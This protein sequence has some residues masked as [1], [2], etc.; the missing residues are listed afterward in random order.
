VCAVAYSYQPQTRKANSPAAGSFGLLGRCPQP[1]ISIVVDGHLASPP[2]LADTQRRGYRPPKA[3]PLSPFFGRASLLAVLL[4]PSGRAVYL[5]LTMTRL[6]TTTRLA[7]PK[8][9]FLAAFVHFFVISAADP[10][11]PA[12][13]LAESFSEPLANTL[14]RQ[15]EEPSSPNVVRGEAGEQDGG[16]PY[17]AAQ[18]GAAPSSVYAPFSG[19]IYIVNPGGG[20]TFDSASPAICP[21]NAP[22]SC[23]NLN[24]W[25]WYVFL[26]TCTRLGR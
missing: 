14:P 13:L 20:R 3:K 23:G 1:A 25:N 2:I 8:I 22:Q 6:R 11:R 10:E 17:A 18:N 12:A 15:A 19:A 7:A 16:A 26:P 24:V 4:P 5:I 21:N 9:L